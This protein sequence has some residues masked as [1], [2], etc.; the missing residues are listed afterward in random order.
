MTARPWMKFYPSD[1][2]SD[3]RLRSCSGAARGLWIE[4]LCIMHSAEPCGYLLV[5]GTPPSI[6]LLGTLAGLPEREVKRS[7]DELRVAGVFSVLDDGVIYSRRIVR[8]VEK[9]ARD[10]ENGKGGGNP[11]LNGG[12]NPPDNG[13]LKAHILE[14]RSQSTPSQEEVLGRGRGATSD[15][16]SFRRGGAA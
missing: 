13:G 8:D 1:W 14:A 11:R 2:Q 4:M 15:V 16:V 12:V 10:K 7:L 3:H 5:A 6:A 9:A